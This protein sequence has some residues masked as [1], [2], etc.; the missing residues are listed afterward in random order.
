[1]YE[2]E[3]IGLG[4]GDPYVVT[5]LSS[6]LCFLSIHRPLWEE[7]MIIYIFYTW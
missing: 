2:E 1:M 6:L 4:T 7:A 5:Y 3:E